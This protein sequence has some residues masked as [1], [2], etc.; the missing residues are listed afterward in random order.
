MHQQ[1]AGHRASSAT[2]RFVDPV[3]AGP[4]RVAA[5]DSGS[6][7]GAD[8][9]GF[10]GVDDEL[11]AVVG[12]ELE[13]CAADVGLGG[14]GADNELVGDLAVGETR[15]HEREDLACARRRVRR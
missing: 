13:H 4:A 3:E 7:A 12:A 5:A 14:V 6:P 1:L 15:C 11:G 9:S 2:A 8:E 10:V